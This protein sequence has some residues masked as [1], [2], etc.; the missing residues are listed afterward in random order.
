VVDKVNHYA[1]LYYDGRLKK[2]Y[3]VDLGMSWLGDKVRRGDNATPEGKYKIIRKMGPS[4]TR[5]YRALLLNYPNEEDRR[6]FVE[7]KRKGQISGRADIGGSIEIH[8]HG[9]RGTDWTQGC[10]ALANADMDDLCRYVRVG[11][12]VTIVG[13]RGDVP[14]AQ[15]NG[16]TQL[17]ER[18]VQTRKTEYKK[19]WRSRRS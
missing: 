11:T 5:Y 10:V 18:P 8:G 12:P 6:Q 3:R 15:P 19:A 17:K 7:L 14:E 16:S 9:G 2:R 4:E 1:D 13:Y